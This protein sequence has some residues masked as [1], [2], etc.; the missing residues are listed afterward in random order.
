MMDFTNQLILLMGLLFLLCVLAS[1]VSARI[2]MP[3]LLVFLAIGM[4]VGE[5]G[6]G[7]IS[8][9]DVETTYRIG[10]LTLAVILFNGGLCTDVRSFRVGLWPA[11]WLA[12][13]GVVITGLIAGLAAAWFLQLPWLEGLLIGAM[14]GSTDAAAVF[15]ILHSH[16]LQLKERVDATLQI[17]SGINDPMAIFLTIALVGILSS[18]HAQ[19]DWQALAMLFAQQMGVGA[20]VGLAGG[21]LLLWLLDR[22]DPGPGMHPLLAFAGALLVFGATAV[23][24]GSGY[25]AVYLAGIVIGNS[26]RPLRG[27][28]NI[29]RFHDGMA[30]LS[31]ISMFLILGL[32]VTPKQLL[33]VAL[34]SLLIA[35]VLILIARPVAVALCLLPFRFAW[36]EQ[37]FIGWI[38]LRGAVPIILALFPWL[39]GLADA[40]L[41]FNVVFFVVLLSL[42]IQGWTVAWTARRLRLE[43]PPSTSPLVER[44]QLD[45]PRSGHELVA[46]RMTGAIL[47]R[48]RSL[49]AWWL[50]AQVEPVAIL[51]E[52]RL[53][54]VREAGAL[55]ADDCLY[56]FARPEDLPLLDQ[57]F[58]TAPPSPRLDAGRFFGELSLN[59]EANMMEVARLY[60]FSLGPDVARLN[61]ED[62]LRE[63]F[64]RPVVGDRIKLGSVEFVVREMRNERIVR[65]GLK[66]N[67]D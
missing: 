33:P 3:L 38:G 57:L 12:T 67:P 62:L 50:P 47:P 15:S 54:S 2:G 23:S 14:V 22:I 24:G 8:F 43:V 9:D 48:P 32:L 49:D 61:L 5:D 18:D 11:L 40:R 17:E 37:M 41:F 53:M 56:L 30:W 35:L 39:G 51:R 6:P 34:P 42:V 58:A 16:G 29:R 52:G 46:Y 26:P 21:K 27:I 19:P 63:Q 1:V 28:Q 7:G 36:R 60:G 59:A 13:V 25:L 4:L 31:Q 45:L 65:V 66:L 55:Q 44:L 64:A 10:T 20:L